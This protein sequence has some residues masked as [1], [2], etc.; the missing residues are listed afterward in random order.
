[1]SDTVG[2]VVVSHSRALGEAAAELA[3]EMV[4]GDEVRIEVAAGLAEHTLGTD[5]TAIA[6]A[7]SRADGGAGVVVLMDL[8]SAVLSAELALEFH[9]DPDSVLLCPAPL[10]EGLVAAAVAAAGGADRATVAAEAGQGT[11]AKRA[12]LGEEPV[13][14]SR[15]AASR[16]DRVE[17]FTVTPPHGLHARPAAL[18]V[19]AV[20][21]FDARVELVDLTTG[22]G[23]VSAAGLTGVAAL[24]AASGDEIEVRAT[25]P[26]AGDAVAALLDLA[27]GGF[28]EG[29]SAARADADDPPVGSDA[30]AERPPPSP[31]VDH[32]PV[33]GS[34]GI[35]LGPARVLRPTA[36]AVPAE[37]AGTPAVERARLAA[38]VAAARASITAVRDATPGAE[39]AIFDAHLLML[40]DPALV[41]VADA[42]I[43][44]GRSAAAAWASAARDA[45]A[46]LAAL[47]GEYLRARAAD[48][49]AV[50]DEVLRALVADSGRDPDGPPDSEARVLL[51][52]D[53][54]PAEA[55]TLSA[56]GVVLAGGSPT[57]HA[58]IIL[59]ARGIPAVLGAG[60][61]VLDTPDGTLVA[62]DGDTGEL[63][64]DPPDPDRFRARRARAR[65]RERAAEDR[66]HEPAVTPDGTRVLVGVNLGAEPASEQGAPDPAPGADLAGLVRTEFL[67]LDRGRAPSVD[68]QEAAYRAVARA[69]GGRRVVLRT[70]DVGGDKPLPYLPQPPEANPFLGVRGLRLALARPDLLDDQLRAIV[71]VARD[72]PVSVLFPMVTVP[73]ELD[74]ARAALARAQEREGPAALQVGI[75]VEVPAAALTAAR[76]AAGVDFFSIG[77]NDLTQYTLAAERGNP[78]LAPLGDALHPAVLRLVR[79]VCDT[80]VPTAVCGELAA[81]PRAV[82]LLVGLGVRELSVAPPAVA[83]VKQAVRESAGL[84]PDLWTTRDA[85]AVRALLPEG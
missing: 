35:A 42:G 62:V 10:V 7:L 36:L 33:A 12:Q 77:T 6:E 54:T 1:M 14:P 63:Q 26:Q 80:G 75:M 74:A 64:V 44:A 18:L 84:P 46:Q 15:P 81:D 58:V 60:E 73:A 48:V 71:R 27:A 65:A 24:G 8:G 72:H 29:G 3:R 39:A 22:R 23:P 51:A 59:R 25:G 2:L 78:R 11:A 45:A 70:L 67:F 47:P 61:E 40:D 76:F 66:R 69:M 32:G 37:P 43:D 20:A 55:A 30:V 82:G 52:A 21:G 5:A 9:D 79:E 16:P 34:P 56:A 85:E 53:L 49:R 50:G 83:R 57:A 17:R 13:A 41:E 4:P 28:G 68:E 19:R 38:A 31:L